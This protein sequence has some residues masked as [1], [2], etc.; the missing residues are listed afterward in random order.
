MQLTPETAIRHGMRN[1]SDTGEKI[2]GGASIFVACSPAAY[3][4]GERKGDLYRRVPPFKETQQYVRKGR[5]YHRV[6]RS[7]ASGVSFHSDLLP[8]SGNGR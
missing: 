3:H 1:F 2:T 7:T 6:Y 5:A 8:Q 4:A